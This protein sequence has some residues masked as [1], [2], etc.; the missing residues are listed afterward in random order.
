MINLKVQFL[1]ISLRIKY[2]QVKCVQKE[3]LSSV[4]SIHLDPPTALMH[5]SI[6]LWSKQNIQAFLYFFGAKI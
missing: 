3:N 5:I 4:L 2:S 6:L 1:L